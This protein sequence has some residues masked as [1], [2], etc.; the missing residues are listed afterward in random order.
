MKRLSSLTEINLLR[1]GLSLFV[2]CGPYM[3]HFG[4]RTPQDRSRV[5]YP[6]SPARHVVLTVGAL[7]CPG[8]N[9]VL[10]PGQC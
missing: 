2:A 8:Q 1:A 10:H 4:F 3:R 9:R 7:T 5:L 6:C